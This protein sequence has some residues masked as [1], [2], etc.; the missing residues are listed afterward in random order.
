MKYFKGPFETVLRTYEN[1]EGTTLSIVRALYTEKKSGK[2]VNECF[3]GFTRSSE[4]PEKRSTFT[5][6]LLLP[7]LP[8][9]IYVVNFAS[10]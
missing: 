8:D 6:I 2:S 7:P 1:I 5:P 3:A 10:S 9:D 4:K